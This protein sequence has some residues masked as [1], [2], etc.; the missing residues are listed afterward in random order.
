M[1]HT[2]FV[3]QCAE[4]QTVMSQCRCMSP[5]KTIEWSLCDECIAT[6]KPA[7]CNHEIVKCSECKDVLS[8]C[9][10][11]ASDKIIKPSMEW[12]VCDACKKKLIY[13]K[14]YV[15]EIE[16]T[17]NLESQQVRIRAEIHFLDA[18]DITLKYTQGDQRYDFLQ[19]HMMQS[20]PVYLAPNFLL[21]EEPQS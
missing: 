4:C 10:C 11:I 5:D 12:V 19:E 8:N 6:G 2:H 15:H 13:I 3:K 16:C 7:A 9:E 14:G 20:A 21:K 17:P 1:S 18:T